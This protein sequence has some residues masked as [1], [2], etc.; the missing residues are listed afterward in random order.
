MLLSLH[1]FL[2]HFPQVPLRVTGIYYSFSLKPFPQPGVPA[3]HSPAALLPPVAIL[4]HILPPS[5]WSSPLHPRGLWAWVAPDPAPEAPGWPPAG[6]LTLDTCAL[7]DSGQPSTLLL[8][9]GQLPPRCSLTARFS[10]LD[11]VTWPPLPA[12]CRCQPCGASSPRAVPGVPAL[13]EPPSRRLPGRLA[14]R[15]LCL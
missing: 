10:Q 12:S 11:P 2:P 1:S 13:S 14:P 3:P 4:L 6:L 7:P 5:S 9:P 15:G 8:L